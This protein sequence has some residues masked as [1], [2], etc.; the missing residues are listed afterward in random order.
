MRALSHSKSDQNICEIEMF[1]L[2]L[3]QT[4]QFYNNYLNPQNTMKT[5]HSILAALVLLCSATLLIAC[6]SDDDENKSDNTNAPT[7]VSMSFFIQVTDDMLNYLD[8]E[9]VAVAGDGASTSYKVTKDKVKD[10]VYSVVV[11]GKLPCELKVTKTVT[12]KEGVDFS[13]VESFKYYNKNNGYY[14]YWLYNAN[15]EMIKN[16]FHD[17][18]IRSVNPLT[19]PGRNVQKFIDAVN[20]GMINNTFTITL[21]KDGDVVSTH[22]ANEEEI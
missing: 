11:V 15:Q 13:N 6:G 12:V 14:Q 3:Q 22:V 10:G 17:G 21:N 1:C 4:M 5:R 18:G 16:A 20:E 19:V 2:L 9:L 7:W 8:M